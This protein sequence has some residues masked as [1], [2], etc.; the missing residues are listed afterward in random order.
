MKSAFVRSPR[1]AKGQGAERRQEI[2]DA[3]LVHDEAE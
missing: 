1:K 2:L 3:A